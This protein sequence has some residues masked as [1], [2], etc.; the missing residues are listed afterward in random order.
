MQDWAGYLAFR[1]AF[2]EVMDERYHTLPWL[3]EQIL[4]GT[5]KFWRSANA[6][7]LTEIKTYPT[8]ATDIHVV[9]SAGDMR[10]VIE[11]LRPRAEQFGRENGC[12]AATV[13]SRE[14]WARALKPHGYQAF[15]LTV[16]KELGG[17]IGP[18]EEQN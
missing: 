13:E 17:D 6:A 7:L 11:I 2:Q 15:Q 12:I 9:I 14:G 18:F 10:E 8:G 16:R 5:V 4:T 1:E 3:D